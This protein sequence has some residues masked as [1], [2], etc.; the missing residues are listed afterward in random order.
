MSKPFGP[1][2]AAMLI[3]AGGGVAMAD[4]MARSDAEQAFYELHRSV[5]AV[6]E[7]DGRTFTSEE[8]RQLNR[9]ITERAGLLIGPGRM[10]TL[11]REAERDARNAYRLVACDGEQ[12]RTDLTRYEQSLEDIAP[13]RSPFD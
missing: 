3:L 9:G 11:M 8:T 12:A 5:A 1:V 7:C 13:R 6:R 4:A 2:V 10:L